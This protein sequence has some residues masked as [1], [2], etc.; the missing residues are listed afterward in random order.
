MLQRRQGNGC[1]RLDADTTAAKANSGVVPTVNHAQFVHRGGEGFTFIGD[2]ELAANIR[3]KLAIDIDVLCI[4]TPENTRLNKLKDEPSL[5]V[6]GVRAPRDYEGC[7]FGL[8]A[9]MRGRVKAR[10]QAGRSAV[11]A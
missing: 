2:D 7:V 5:A 4:V 1:F 11:R 10:D 9:I 3:R 8:H 6:L